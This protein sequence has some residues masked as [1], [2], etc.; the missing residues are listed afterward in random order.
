[1]GML[2]VTADAQHLGISLLKP[3][4]GLVKR[5]DLVPSTTCKVED[6]E[7]EDQVLLTPELAQGDLG[8]RLVG[9]GEVRGLLTGFCCHWIPPLGDAAT[10]SPQG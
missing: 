6:V 2:A 8:S 4:V 7:R 9:K 1:M 3:G 10:M 5:G